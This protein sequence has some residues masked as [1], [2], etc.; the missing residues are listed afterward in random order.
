MTSEAPLV[1]QLFA[2]GPAAEGPVRA[3]Q[4]GVGPP[5]VPA[6]EHFTT[7]LADELATAAVTPHVGAELYRGRGRGKRVTTRGTV[8][9]DTQWWDRQE[10]WRPGSLRLPGHFSIPTDEK[11]QMKKHRIPQVDDAYCPD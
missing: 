8:T 9:R 10:I 4:T 2:A 11:P 7:G 1:S 5:P 6:A 3:V